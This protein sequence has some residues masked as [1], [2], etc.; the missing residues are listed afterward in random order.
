MGAVP[1]GRFV[2]EPEKLKMVAADSRINIDIVGNERTGDMA[3][4]GPFA[5]WKMDET[6]SIDPRI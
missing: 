6:Y 4:P 1:E 5:K 2:Y 3:V